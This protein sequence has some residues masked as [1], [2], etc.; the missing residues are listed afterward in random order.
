MY[1]KMLIAVII[2]SM[3]VIGYASFGGAPV[4]AS[5]NCGT[6][7]TVLAANPELSEA[8]RYY[9]AAAVTETALPRAIEASAA[10]YSGM[11]EYY[12]AAKET[13]NSTY[14]ATNPELMIT[15]Q[16]IPSQNK[17]DPDSDIGLL[18]FYTGSSE[19]GGQPNPYERTANE[20]EQ[21]NKWYRINH[22]GR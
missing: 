21:W 12:A 7:S 17:V 13:T 4:Q 6:D 15:H 8:C 18:E 9:D 1:Q 20:L 11:A 19:T 14:L 16:F 3:L 5:H 2:V 22:P 10:R